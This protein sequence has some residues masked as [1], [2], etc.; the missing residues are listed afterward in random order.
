MANDSDKVTVTNISVQAEVRRPGL[1][2]VAGR[3]QATH[4]RGSE[5]RTEDDPGGR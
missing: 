5:A 3:R 2:Q 4:R 1:C